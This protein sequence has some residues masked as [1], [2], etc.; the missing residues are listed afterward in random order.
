LS[1]AAVADGITVTHNT[2]GPLSEPGAQI[3]F[4]NARTGDKVDVTA[5][6]K[7]SLPAGLKLP[8]KAGD[9][10]KVSVSDGKN[11]VDHSAV[12]G[13]LKVPG[14]VTPPR[15]PPPVARRLS[16]NDFGLVPGK[17]QIPA[18][19]VV[20]DALELLKQPGVSPFTALTRAATNLGYPL[21]PG[22]DSGAPDRFLIALGPAALP[23][24]SPGSLQVCLSRWKCRPE[25]V[26]PA[27]MDLGRRSPA[28]FLE[29]MRA[30]A[31]NPSLTTAEVFAVQDAVVRTVAR[32]TPQAPVLDGS[33]TLDTLIQNTLELGH[34]LE[35]GRTCGLIAHQLTKGLVANPDAVRQLADRAIVA[36]DFETRVLASGLFWRS[37]DTRPAAVQAFLGSILSDAPDWSRTAYLA[38]I[39]QLD[40]AD[41][42][43]MPTRAAGVSAEA[44]ATAVGALLD[45]APPDAAID[46]VVHVASNVPVTNL[47]D[48]ARAAV[49]RSRLPVARKVAMADQLYSQTDRLVRGDEALQ[50]YQVKQLLSGLLRANPEASVHA[51]NLLDDQLL[52]HDLDDAARAAA[53]KRLEGPQYLVELAKLEAERIASPPPLRPDIPSYMEESVRRWQRGVIDFVLHPEPKAEEALRFLSTDRFPQYG[54]H[55]MEELAVVQGREAGLTT[56]ELVTA[57]M[58][59]PLNTPPAGQMAVDLLCDPSCSDAVFAQHFAKVFPLGQTEA[60]DRSELP[61]LSPE[62]GSTTRNGQRDLVRSLLSRGFSNQVVAE[63]LMKALPPGGV[64]GQVL[65]DGGLSPEVVSALCDSPGREYMRSLEYAFAPSTEVPRNVADVF[66]TRLAGYQQKVSALAPSTSWAEGT[67]D[68][69]RAANEERMKRVFSPEMLTASAAEVE[70]L[71]PQDRILV[72][73]RR[74]ASYAELRARYQ[75]LRLPWALA[76]GAPPS[77]Q[78]EVL[79]T[80]TRYVEGLASFVA[81][82]SPALSDEV[83]RRVILDHLTLGWMT[84]TSGDSS[85]P[86]LR[87]VRAGWKGS[88]DFIA[89]PMLKAIQSK[90]IG[91]ETVMELGALLT[92]PR[93]SKA[94]ALQLAWSLAEFGTPGPRGEETDVWTRGNFTFGAAGTA[95]YAV[96]KFAAQRADLTAEERRELQKAQTAMAQGLPR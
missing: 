34:G 55:W 72:D 36:G 33:V 53:R 37:S 4:V 51:P 67:L 89:P 48:D 60:W 41:L 59:R 27:L 7:G 6:D 52:V 1:L 76:D 70:R 82:A 14:G 30:L 16:L 79:L 86:S 81:V 21:E 46:A 78:L 65:L 44:I 58:K 9:E 20:A 45:D 47:L 93:L 75:D 29:A 66:A 77:R 94:Q 22:M 85:P 18:R 19:A 31:R 88:I 11:N 12:T 8:G 54:L 15:P 73:V 24:V 92:D 28:A 3:R 23:L 71:D 10:F 42:W 63:L 13:T 35:F 96:G 32:G 2:A 62:A 80:N 43:G 25:E 91:A 68:P 57:L 50:V 49:G 95:A 38:S 84:N 61:D 5:T 69:A 87:A 64:N 17:P 26:M 40:R 56:D 90:V 83:R 39:A 74:G